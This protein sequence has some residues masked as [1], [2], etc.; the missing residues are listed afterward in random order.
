[1]PSPSVAIIAY[2]TLENDIRLP[3]TCVARHVDLIVVVSTAGAHSMVVD[4]ERHSDTAAG[5]WAPLV[6]L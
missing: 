2:S 5:S 3:L 4:H 6:Q 1:M